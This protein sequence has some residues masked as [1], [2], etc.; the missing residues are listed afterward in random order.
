MPV[1]NGGG[2][3]VVGEADREAVVDGRPAKM[4][5]ALRW[6]ARPEVA[7][8]WRLALCDAHAA[9]LESY[10]FLPIDAPEG[11]ELRSCAVCERP[12]LLRVVENCTCESD[13]GRCPEHSNLGCSC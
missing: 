8:P 1:D 6:Y 2:T 10:R 5:A 9:A 4:D 11:R 13:A 12:D 3:M 7:G